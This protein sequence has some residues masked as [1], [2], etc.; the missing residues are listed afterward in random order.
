MTPNFK[1]GSDTVWPWRLLAGLLIVASAALHVLYLT[2]DDSLDLA[3]DEAH[4]WD[5]SRHLDWSYYSKGP[6]VAFL[7]RGG[8]EL[9]GDWSQ[10]LNANEMLAVRL[11]AVICGS[12]L[13]ASLYL[14]TTQVFQ[15]ERLAA[16]VVAI[17]LTLP[18]IGAGST[19]MTI[20]SPYTCCWGWTLVTGH[21]AVF[22]RSAWA[23]P[24][25]GLLVGIGILA[26]YTMVLF[27]PSLGLFLLTS[28]QYRGLLLRLGFWVMA[29]SA[30]ACSLPILMWNWEHDW[31]TVRHVSGLAGGHGA[32][33]VNWLGPL[34]YI[35]AQCGLLLI[36]WFLVWLAAMVAYR[37]WRT[38]VP[39]TAYLWWLSA[40]M[41]ATFLIFSFKTGGGEPNWPI[42]AYISGLVLTA[43]WIANML[44]SSEVWQRRLTWACLS[45]TCGVGLALNIVMHHSPWLYPLFDR[46]AGEPTNERPLPMRRFD[47]TCRL[48]GWR[49]L[50]PAVDKLR[51]QIR[52]PRAEAILACTSW[53]LPGE[54]GFYC[55]GHPQVYSLGLSLG[56]RHSQ[57]D[58][59]H[60][61]P[62]ADSSVFFGRTFIIV[63][64]FTPEA[65][66]QAF[67]RVEKSELVTHYENGQPVAQWLVTVARGF[68]GFDKALGEGTE[69][70]Y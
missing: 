14:L 65:L 7:I 4:Y 36:Y 21:Q 44:R 67:E 42:T 37:P 5:W 68:K 1:L 6:L 9:A 19:L 27:L 26:K 16:G 52:T 69:R 47:P 43:A 46:F 22:R 25:T 55:Q 8:C 41:F 29:G 18:V 63:G 59:W 57:Y 45:L 64:N 53:S 17:A 49:T 50:A 11:P 30:A 56:D 20:D 23:W 40:P 48:R 12:L 3:P 10:Q 24:A 15:N 62:I 33:G 34:A 2:S 70:S 51:Q 66:A 28:R 32:S 39:A 60:P 61:N 13:L 31:P 38:S 54:L 35:A 58:L